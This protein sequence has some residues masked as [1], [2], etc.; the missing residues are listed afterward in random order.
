[1]AGCYPAFVPTESRRHGG[2]RI[3]RLR[4]TFALA[5][6]LAYLV[7]GSLT[8]AAFLLS[9]R[10]LITAFG[11]RFAVT[12]ALL[13]KNKVLSRIDREVALSQKLVDD[14]LLVQWALSEDDPALRT[15]A[16][17]SLESYRRVF[18]AHSYFIALDRSKHYY[19]CDANAAVKSL[20][21][22]TL[23]AANP[24]DGWYF[25]TLRSVES[26]ALNL[27]YDRTIKSIRVWIN[28][29]MRDAAGRKIGIGGTGIDLTD[30]LQEVLQSGEKGALIMLVDNDG[31]IE[32]YPTL[33]YVQRNATALSAADKLTVFDLLGDRDEAD[34]LRSALDAL[35][36]VR[37]QVMSLP[38][39]VEG[40]R[41]LVAA[42]FMPEIAWFNLVLVDT[43]GVVGLR[44]LLPFAA[45][46]IASLLLVLLAVALT[47]SRAVLRPLSA[48]AAASRD[49]S[50]GRYGVS[51]PVN[52]RDEIGQLTRSFNEMSEK[53]LEATVGLEAK[54]SERTSALTEANRALESSQAQIMESLAHAR[55]LQGGI[56]PAEQSLRAGLADH[57]VIYSPRD[58][59]GGDFYVF[60]RSNGHLVAAV[61]DCMGHGVPGAFMTMSAHAVLSHVLDS[62]VNDDPSRILAELD[63]SLRDTLHA[64]A[65]ESR[66]DAGLDI[67]L[68]V[69]QPDGT[70][71]FAGAGLPLYY[72]DGKRVGELKGERRR[73]GYRSARS[74][75]D[76]TNQSLHLGHEACLYL[77][78]DG[79]LDQAGGRKGYGFGAERFV[80]L[81]ESGA[82]IP[83][84][85]Q[86][87]A[88][89]RC[90]ASYQEARQQRDDIT[91]FAFKIDGGRRS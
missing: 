31:A 77:T 57:F 42:A 4:G 21:I 79:F 84:A 46:V 50:G 59:V 51:L 61:V 30:F 86:A 55:R 71:V 83:L 89:R 60:H 90:L 56:L 38:L 70:V 64:E 14:P 45:T 69:C 65:E 78:T 24:A 44:D 73:V 27:D 6:A 75:T 48:L 12:E 67:G 54:V 19:V 49:I 15:L 28:A 29:V 63:G 91:V 68:C 72:W 33:A 66:L 41:Y 80:A 7:I 82:S 47:L 18:A 5:I 43:T 37:S 85:G 17:Q 11:S 40:R 20:Q 10:S 39:E 3:P 1:M 62:I 52:R 36:A 13:E 8:L 88:F 22:T 25:E 87:D 58:V 32:A 34:R 81:I 53:V 74:A 76:W 2:N 9:A 16:L 26:F 35:R 23:S